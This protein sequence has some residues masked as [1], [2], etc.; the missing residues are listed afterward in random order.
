MSFNPFAPEGAIN[1]R[2]QSDVTLLAAVQ[3]IY[4]TA[5]PDDLSIRN[6]L[7]PIV[8]V[9]HL[10]GSFDDTFVNNM[11][12]HEYQV[13]VFDSRNNGVVPAQTVLARIIGNSRGTD[14]N[15]T[16]G[17]HRWQVS[18]VSGMENARMRGRQ[19]GAPHDAEAY[20][21]WVTFAIEVQE[22]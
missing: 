15:P 5:I 2:L 11:V 6:T 7:K 22:A 3:G 13:S 9:T 18:S 21:Y 14:N 10:S 4:N 12:S 17:L 16:Y 1:N 8:V 19:V 20:H